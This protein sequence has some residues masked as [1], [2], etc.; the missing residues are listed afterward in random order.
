MDD[1]I[2]PM[3]LRSLILTTL[4]LTTS[5]AMMFAA[6]IT[7]DSGHS[8]GN[9]EVHVSITGDDEYFDRGSQFTVSVT[10]SNL[11]SATEY[12][13]DWQL[14]AADPYWEWD[15]DLQ[16]DIIA[17]EC[18]GDYIDTD[19]SLSGTQTIT[20]SAATQT[21]TFTFDDPG[22]FEEWVDGNGDWVM[23]GLRNG[24]YVIEV[25]LNIQGV[26]LTDNFSDAFTMGGHL[27]EESEIVDSDNILI[28]Q[29]VSP[30]LT[31]GFDHE[32]RYH[33]TYDVN[34]GLYED[35]VATVVDTDSSLDLTDW[36]EWIDVGDMQLQPNN[37]GTH[38]IECAVHRDADGTLMGALIGNDFDVVDADV[39]GEEELIVSGS[40]QYYDRSTT[41][42]TTQVTLS[43]ELTDLYVGTE[44]TLDWQLC[45]A[46]PYWE[47]DDD[48]QQDIIAHECYGDYIDTD[49]S[50]S[51]TQ[52]ITASAA[53]QTETFTFDDPG[54]FEEWVD[55]NGD[56][57]MGGLRNGTYVIE[58]ELN[59]QGVHLTD[60]FS[61]AF[62]MG[63]HL[64]EESEIV[65]SDNILISQTVSPVLTI[66][67]DH[68]LRYHLTY[69]VNCGL[70][71][72]GV[73]T[74]VDTDSSLDLTDWHEWIDVGD[75]QLQPN[76]GGTH[77]IECAV[78]RDADG[79]LMGRLIGNDFDVIDDTSNQDDATIA[80]SHAI[81]SVEGWATVTIIASDLD[82]GQA[83]SLIWDVGDNSMIPPVDMDDGHYE[84]VEGTDGTEIHVIEFRALSDSTDACFSV[85]FFAGEDVLQTEYAICWNQLSISDVDQ[86]GVHDKD[87][88]CVDTPIG[89]PNVQANGCSDTDA[90]GWPDT[91]EI[92]CGTSVSDGTD[93]PVDTDNDELCDAIDDDDDNDGVLDLVELASGTNPFDANSKPAN[94][95]PTCGVHY[96]LEVDGIPDTIT[97]TAVIPAL[98]ATAAAAASSG[99][100]QTVTI[101]A[102][103][104]YIIVVCEDPD[105][106]DITVT[107]NDV[108]VGPL[109]GVVKAGAI[110]E[111][112]PDVAETV[113]VTITW[114]DGTDTATSTVTVN[115]DGSAQV[116]SSS[117]QVPGFTMS[118]GLVAMLSA[119]FL[120]SRRKE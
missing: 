16:Q 80:V 84:W 113:D 77:H 8:T 29:T 93:M 17:H 101:P 25:E 112:G 61:D 100:G 15:D 106:D 44:Y 111:I 81:D 114:T 42:T 58:V 1:H 20:A 120:F 105:G 54:I 12:T 26:H 78:H 49:T 51:G 27:L 35:G 108:T 102:G 62:T 98:S 57:V 37:G 59:I 86:D 28:S 91:D 85:T 22:I 90:D 46:D 19:T 92:A 107:V 38:H 63:G 2:Q 94:L 118:F 103:N 66:G 60:N 39:T 33:L 5:L 89:T 10:S 109:S 104:Y 11:D 97:G 68:E 50:L 99:S 31:I 87:D 13:L 7:A 6:P 36:H 56:W 72:D 32:L 9:E 14:C 95:L 76:N 23:G 48:L 79:T 24:T 110:I 55:G 65:D 64:L 67:F 18:Y 82:A 47:W 21:E 116:P 70:Y 52:T 4:M 119:A 30:V 73:A 43:V 117:G 69:D 41:S 96:T 71:E 74:V 53:T 88:E 40:S 3:R 75:M 34:C 45:A 115:L 83:Y